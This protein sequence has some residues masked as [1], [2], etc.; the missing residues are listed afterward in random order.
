MQNT[1]PTPRAGLF[2]ST[3]AALCAVLLFSALTPN[4]AAAL[5]EEKCSDFTIDNRPCTAME[6]FG[7]CLTN[8]I[9]S[10]EEC[11]EGAGWLMKAG[12]FV[13]YEAD[14]IACA[15]QTPFVSIIDHIKAE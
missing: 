9:E 1:I 6:E 2:R 12:C 15:L 5:A 4:I 8:A 7:Y 10:Y 13:A 11:K 3:F 14:Y